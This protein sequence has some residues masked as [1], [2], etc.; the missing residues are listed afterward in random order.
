MF[1]TMRELV[2]FA[3][4]LGYETQRRLPVDG[5]TNEIDARI[6]ERSETAMDLLY[7]IALSE[8][9][10]SD[11]LM[12]DREDYAVTIFEEYAAGG[13]AEIREWLHA[14]P[15]DQH[16]EQALLNGLQ[17]RGLMEA[18]QPEVDDILGQVTF[19]VAGR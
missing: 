11:V 19:D 15:E 3:A 8:E 1:P 9:K 6:F 14:R 10:K 18:G 13:L 4:A 7:L 16:G 5:P 17:K 12:P 2:C